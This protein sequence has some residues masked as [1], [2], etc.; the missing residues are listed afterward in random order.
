MLASCASQDGDIKK[1]STLCY[2]SYP[3]LKSHLVIALS[4]TENVIEK[5]NREGGREVQHAP[6]LGKYQLLDYLSF[7]TIQRHF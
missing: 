1:M 2:V 4:H 6:T 5:T 3:Y 7:D